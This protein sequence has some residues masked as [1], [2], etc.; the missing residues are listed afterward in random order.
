MLFFFICL[1]AEVAIFFS[2]FPLGSR[3]GNGPSPYSEG[4]H[5]S[6]RPTQGSA[7]ITLSTHTLLPLGIVVK[8]GCLRQGKLIGSNGDGGERAALEVLWRL[9]YIDNIPQDNYRSIPCQPPFPSKMTSIRH[10]WVQ[11]YFK[12]SLS[13]VEI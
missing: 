4:R 10:F 3:Y 5:P 1:V 9:I 7:N 2:G 6:R 13:T 11:G 8:N 12:P